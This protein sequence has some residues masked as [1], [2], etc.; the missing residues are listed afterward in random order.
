MRWTSSVLNVSVAPMLKL[1][2]CLLSYPLRHGGNRLHRSSW[3]FLARGRFRCER[4][5]GG[6][7]RRLLFRETLF[8][9]FHQINHGSHMRLRHFGH[10][11]AFELGGDHRAYILLIFVAILLWLERSRKTFNELSR[12]LLLLLFHFDLIGRNGFSGAYLV[13]IKHRVQRHTLGPRP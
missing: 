2:G 9:G 11:L 4:G 6:R 10:F 5:R 13:G 3:R 1:A 8:E 12:E 7:S